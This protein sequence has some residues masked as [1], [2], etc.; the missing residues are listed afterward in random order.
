MIRSMII[1][2]AA[3]V[4]TFSAASGP[5]I[6]METVT[7]V[8]ERIQRVSVARQGPRIRSAPTRTGVNSVNKGEALVVK[9]KVV[10]SSSTRNSIRTT[11]LWGARLST[12]R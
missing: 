5:A 10:P 1:S 6:S 2:A 7:I 8:S 12:A 11:P 3:L 4:A 9:Q